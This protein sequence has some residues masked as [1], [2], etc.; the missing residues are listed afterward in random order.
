M[1]FFSHTRL[2]SPCTFRHNSNCIYF[3]TGIRTTRVLSRLS[4]LNVAT[5]KYECYTPF[6]PNCGRSDSFVRGILKL[7]IEKALSF[8]YFSPIERRRKRSKWPSV[9]SF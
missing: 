8:N 5:K 3:L 7:N 9:H 1:I 2:H 4:H 6:A